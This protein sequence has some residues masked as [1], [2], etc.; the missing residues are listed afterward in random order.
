MFFVCFGKA[1]NQAA[2]CCYP[3][4]NQKKPVR[5]K[6]TTKFSCITT[7]NYSVEMCVYVHD[8]KKIIIIREVREEEEEAADG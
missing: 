3:L 7:L 4:K 1:E 2:A 8:I 6:V 5:R